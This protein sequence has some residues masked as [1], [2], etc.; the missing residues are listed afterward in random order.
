MAFLSS[1][2]TII[3]K[4]PNIDIRNSW[5]FKILDKSSASTSIIILTNSGKPD[6]PGCP[7]KT[8]GGDVP[9]AI[10]AWC[11]PREGRPAILEEEGLEYEKKVYY[12]HIRNI[13]TKAPNAPFL[14]Y[15]G[16][17]NNC[18]TVQTLADY[19]GADTPGALATLCLA[20]YVMEAISISPEKYNLLRYRGITVDYTSRTFYRKYF[21]IF[22]VSDSVFNYR[23]NKI[24]NWKI[25]AILLPA[26]NFKKFQDIIGTDI[27]VNTFREVIK[28]LYIINH[29]KLT[30]NDLHTGN[31]MIEEKTNRVL[32]YDWDRSYSERLGPNSILDSDPCDGLCR[33][34]QC[35]FFIQD[36]PIDLLKILC[37]IT[38]SRDNFNL[39]LQDGLRL[40]NFS[41]EG[42]QKFDIIREGINSCTENNCYYTFKDCSSLYKPGQCPKL[43]EALAQMGQ[44]WYQIHGIAF[45]PPGNIDPKRCPLV[46]KSRII[47][48]SAMTAYVIVQDVVP[49]EKFGM[50]AVELPQIKRQYDEDDIRTAKMY[51]YEELPPEIEKSNLKLDESM[52]KQIRELTK[53]PLSKDMKAEI[54]RLQKIPNDQLTW[55]DYANLLDLSD[56]ILYGPPIPIEKPKLKSADLV[57]AEPFVKIMMENDARKIYK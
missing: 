7:T 42:R 11:K 31:V 9:V 3:A 24:I 10:K 28:G 44:T 17:D 29:L 33:S 15:L 14:R 45:R 39:L 52:E 2:E 38:P 40:K 35:N 55:N 56:Y 57:P 16:D 41:I 25:G 21:G 53:H 27:Q 8:Y 20:F 1:V 19:I 50:L 47:V 22:P 23:Y 43:E 32:I 49:K 4:I 6:A 26:I 37:Y 12:N 51:R 34:S 46:N 13:I 54:S 18:S 5:K 30:H 48:A 36:R